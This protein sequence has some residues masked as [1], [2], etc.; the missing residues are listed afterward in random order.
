MK[1]RTR[2]IIKQY[3]ILLW[4]PVIQKI[5]TLAKKGKKKDY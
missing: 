1:K 5:E 2:V 4:E 3:K